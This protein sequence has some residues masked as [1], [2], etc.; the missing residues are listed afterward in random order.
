MLNIIVCLHY[1]GRK[2]VY[3]FLNY[4]FFNQFFLFCFVC[5]LPQVRLYTFKT[6]GFTQLPNSSPLT[7]VN[8]FSLSIHKSVSTLLV[9]FDH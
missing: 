1:S 5:L 8:L 3:S 9:Y 6:S 4:E 2:N 7:D